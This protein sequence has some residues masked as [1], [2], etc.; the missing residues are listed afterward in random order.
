M[1]GVDNTGDSRAPLPDLDD[2]S[3][4]PAFDSCSALVVLPTL[5]EEEGLQQ[6]LA[7]LQGRY[8]RDG[9]ERA[10]VI[11]I[12]GGSTDGTLEVARRAHVPLLHQR[13]RGKGE[14]LLESIE[15]ARKHH[16]PHAVVLD[17]DATY[18][19]DQIAP[20]LALLR[21][22]TDLVVGVRRP[23]GGPPRSLVE[24]V[25]RT[26]NVLLS[27]TASLLSGRTVLDVCSGFWG[28]STER[29][30]ELDLGEAEFAIE[31]ELVVKALRAGLKLAQIPVAYSHR[32]GE[33]KLRTWRDGS[34]IFLSILQFAR[35]A[36]PP[37]V[38]ALGPSERLRDLLSIG[39][40]TGS[41][42]AIISCTPAE[43]D[44]AKRLA[45]ALRRGL[46]KVRIEVGAVGEE[47]DGEGSTDPPP[48][49]VVHLPRETE[50][51]PIPSVTVAIDANGRRLKIHLPSRDRPD[52]RRPPELR[53]NPS[54]ARGP[55][56][57]WP[58]LL[59]VVTSRLDFDPVAQHRTILSANG[60][61]VDDSAG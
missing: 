49:L 17:A 15:W 23:V 39:V 47:Q 42:G 57:G 14:A 32:V 40:I 38:D 9:A 31:A 10:C 22:G 24:L 33:S 59:A 16:I 60:L 3:D 27:G 50:E 1:E 25:H 12:D 61:A 34:A 41:S 55:G 35:S 6:T 51:D 58:S 48:P 21:A 7:G 26:G 56:A 2:A 30:A 4:E 36:P 44:G 52:L 29:F 8:P 5:N 20:A 18:P 37:P 46:P 28:V 45:R 53:D 11:V 54:P 19:P 13:G 43:R